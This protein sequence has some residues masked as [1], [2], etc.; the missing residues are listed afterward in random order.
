MR[1]LKGQITIEAILAFGAAILVF[2]ALTNLNFERLNLA[3]DIGEAGEARM[4]GEL[5]ASAINN[6][7]ANGEGFSVYLNSDKLDY[8]KLENQSHITGIG[9]ILP[10]NINASDGTLNI[11][12]NASKIG[13]IIGELTISIIPR[14]ITRL[15]ATSQ[16][17]QT[18]IRNN[19][20]YII[21]YADSSNIA[22]YKNG[23]RID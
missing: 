5:L 22:V 18:T 6:A 3:R 7:Y 1:A 4:V 9:L 20:T 16:Y 23:S 14:N 2:V 12:K 19:G 17:P 10:L 15:D 21:L 8:E 13:G 11:A